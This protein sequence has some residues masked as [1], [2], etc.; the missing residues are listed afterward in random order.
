MDLPGA[1]EVMETEEIQVKWRVIRW[2]RQYYGEHEWVP[3]DILY[4]HVD[5]ALHP[6]LPHPCDIVFGVASNAYSFCPLSIGVEL[7][8]NVPVKPDH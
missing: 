5:D 1:A 3:E 4:A 8:L 2:L 6:W 7:R